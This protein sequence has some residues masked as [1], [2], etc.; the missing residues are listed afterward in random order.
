MSEVALPRVFSGRVTAPPR[1]V[2]LRVSDDI[3]RNEYGIVTLGNPQPCL[4]EN[5][6]HRGEAEQC[7]IDRDHGHHSAAYYE[8]Q[9]GVASEFRNEE[10]LLRWVFRCVHDQKHEDYPFNVPLPRTRIMK[11]AIKEARLLRDIEANYRARVSLGGVVLRSDLPKWSI[12]AAQKNLDRGMKEKKRL[13]RSVE[14]IEFLPQEI[15]TGALLLPSPGHAQNRLIANPHY[16]LPGTIRP[17]EVFT[18]WSAAEEM[19]ANR[20]E[21]VQ[22]LHAGRQ[23]DDEYLEAV[24]RAA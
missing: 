9:G 11:S 19:L 20:Q 23:L 4:G 21:M 13:L 3:P 16:V 1:E 17:T 10:A 22:A 8:Y 6:R 2:D 5:C 24:A 18:A 15:V 14:E 7:F 12:R